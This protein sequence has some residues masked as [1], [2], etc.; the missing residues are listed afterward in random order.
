MADFDGKGWLRGFASGAMRGCETAERPGAGEV[1]H[2]EKASNK[3]TSE[4]LA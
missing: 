4:S 1:L 3:A 2:I